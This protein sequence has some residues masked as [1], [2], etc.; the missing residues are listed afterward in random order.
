MTEFNNLDEKRQSEYD[1]PNAVIDLKEEHKEDNR[2]V[3][4]Y[5]HNSKYLFG[6]TVD[7]VSFNHFI[8]MKKCEKG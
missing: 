4:V 8:H 5:F 6:D 3:H 1:F 7:N 2:E